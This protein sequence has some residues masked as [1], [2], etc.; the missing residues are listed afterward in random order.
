[1][2]APRGEAHLASGISRLNPVD[3]MFST[4]IFRVAKMKTKKVS[5]A[6]LID[7]TFPVLQPLFHGPALQAH[8]IGFATLSRFNRAQAERANCLFSVSYLCQAANDCSFRLPAVPVAVR[9]ELTDALLP[10]I[11]ADRLHPPALARARQ[12]APQWDSH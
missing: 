11:I 8:T 6:A 1:M 12:F 2:D 7:S 10:V 3:F 9:D 4:W 5:F